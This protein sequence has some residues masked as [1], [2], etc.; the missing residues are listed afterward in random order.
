MM[1]QNAILKSGLNDS[2]LLKLFRMLLPNMV[3]GASKLYH[4]VITYS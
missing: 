4:G 1:P 3:S 2:D